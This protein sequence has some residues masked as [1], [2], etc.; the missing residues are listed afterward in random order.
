MRGSIRQRSAGSWE[1]QLEL[2]RVAGKRHRRFVSVKG[3]KKDAQRELTR[4]LSAADD[5]TL[6][7]PTKQTVG[8]YVRRLLGS[9]LD[10]SPKTLERYR[11]LAERQIIPHLGDIRLQ[12]LQ[13]DHVSQWHATLI[14][15]GLSARTVGHAHRV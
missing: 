13:P 15:G 7:D 14:S 3:T 4:L 2:D 9:S 1:I 5:G 10:Q 8:E 11:E 12:K 6:P